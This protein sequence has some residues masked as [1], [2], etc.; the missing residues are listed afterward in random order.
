MLHTSRLFRLSAAQG[1]ILCMHAAGGLL[2]T[3]GQDRSIRVWNF[4]AQV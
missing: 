2:F 3:G 1:Q 4:N